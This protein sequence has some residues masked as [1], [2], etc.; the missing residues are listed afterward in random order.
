MRDK[1]D[2]QGKYDRALLTHIKPDYKIWLAIG[3]KP[4]MGAGRY[5]I[6]KTI[7]K[8]NSIKETAKLINISYRACQNYIKKM[9]DRLGTEIVHTERGGIAGGGS[10]HLTTFGRSLIKKYESIKVKVELNAK[11]QV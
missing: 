11:R 10:A 3:Q 9:E 5:K 8:T 7:S 1:I 4:I 2:D 6:L